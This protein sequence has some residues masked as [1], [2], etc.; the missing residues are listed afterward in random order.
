MRKIYYNEF[1]KPTAAWLREL[2]AEGLIA[3]GVVDDRPIQ[4]VQQ[5]QL[6]EFT[7][8]HFFAGIGGWSLALRKAGW[9]DDRPVWTGS[10]P[11][12]SFSAAGAKRGFDDP[13]HLW[14]QFF[15]LI[16]E[17][18]P[19]TVFGEQVDDAADRGDK[20]KSWLDLVSSDLGSEG[21]AF[22]AAVFP[23]VYVGAPHLRNRLYFVADSDD[24]KPRTAEGQ[25]LGNGVVDGFWSGADWVRCPDGKRRAV[26]PGVSPM[27]H[28]LPGGV[29]LLRGAGNAIV[30][31]QAA[32][33]IKAYLEVRG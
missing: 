33:F 7:Q 12:Q 5:G 24:A 10:C 14:P 3:E 22:G 30:P 15:R 28:G 16:K 29:E 8:C 18:S 20:T 17:C 9:P 32:E 13:R 25:P 11:C 4:L 21:Y 2:M 6:R 1:D 31:Q 27:A 19:A 26:K 23:A